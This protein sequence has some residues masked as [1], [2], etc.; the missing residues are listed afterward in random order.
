MAFWNMNINASFKK[1]SSGFKKQSPSARLNVQTLEAREVPA[2][3]LG[4]ASDFSAFYFGDVNA[5]NSDIEGRVA[6]GGNASFTAY[7]VGTKLPNSNGTR[8]D[9]IV[10]NNLNFTNG[11]NFAGNTVYG[12]NVTTDMFGH[13]Q[14]DIHKGTPI[15]FAAA[16]AELTNLSNSWKAMKTTGSVS[17]WYGALTLNGNSASQNVFNLTAAQLWDANGITIKAPAGSTVLVNVSGTDARMQFMGMNL[18][19]VDNNH[20]VFNFNQA[21]NLQFQ[22]IGFLGSVVAPKAAFDFSN[23]AIHG[24]VVAKSMSG[25]G[26]IETAN[27]CID[28]KP[29]CLPCP[30]STIKGTVFYDKNNNG[31][32]DAGENTLSNIK[33]TITGIDKNGNKVNLATT[34]DSD[35]NYSFVGLQEGKYTIR[36]AKPTWMHGGKSSAGSFGGSTGVNSICAINVKGCGVVSTGY[37]FGELCGCKD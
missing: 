30:G 15:D 3:G 27:P 33:I 32:I 20:V 13:P 19:G 35:G 22:G 4:V 16:Q 37:N 6:V 26:E 31:V 10:G 8:D 5:Y 29:P 17:N 21:T 11:Q 18:Q 36:S 23:G 7:S 34:T 28:I 25:Y 2:S 9:L 14:G 1:Q 24:T 12:N